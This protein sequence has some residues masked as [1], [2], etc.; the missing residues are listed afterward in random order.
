MLKNIVFG[1]K[2]RDKNKRW[3]FGSCLLDD[4]GEA[5]IIILQYAH[6]KNNFC[7]WASVEVELETICRF[8]NQIDDFKNDIYE[9]DIVRV[10]SE[11]KSFLGKVMFT[12]KGQWGLQELKSNTF[13]SFQELKYDFIEIAGNIFDNQAM[14]RSYVKH[15]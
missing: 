9:N 13:I 12:E 15:A 4:D 14:I 5:Y 2:G 11:G 10:I 7:C 3:F 8:S 1:Y 6:Q